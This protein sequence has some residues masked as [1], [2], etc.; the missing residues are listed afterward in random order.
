M[1]SIKNMDLDPDQVLKTA[2]NSNLCCTNSSF[3]FLYIE[4]AASFL[5]L[6]FSRLCKTIDNKSVTNSIQRLSVN[7]SPVGK[8]KKCLMNNAGTYIL[9]VYDKC[10]YVVELPS[11]WG[12]YEQYNGGSANTMC[13]S[14]RLSH[15]SDIEDAIWH[16][17][18]DQNR[19]VCLTKDNFIRIYNCENFKSSIKEYH[20]QSIFYEPNYTESKTNRDSKSNDQKV[21]ID[22]G[23]KFTFNGK[24][25]F[26]I[27]VLKSGGQ[28][29]CLIDYE[30]TSSFEFLGEL[31]LSPSSNVLEDVQVISIMCLPVHPN[32]IVVQLK[33]FTVYHCLFMPKIKH[34]LFNEDGQQ[35]YNDENTDYN[36]DAVLYI[37]ERVNINLSN[38]I[39]DTKFIKDPSNSSRYFIM[40]LGG[41]HSVYLPWLERLQVCYLNDT[42]LNSVDFDELKSCEFTHLISTRPFSEKKSDSFLVGV[43][44]LYGFGNTSNVLIGINNRAGFICANVQ[45]T[46]MYE[47]AKNQM[48]TV[49]GGKEENITDDEFNKYIS[50]ILKRQYN[51][52]ILNA[53]NVENLSENEL[54]LF[55][56]Q[57]INLIRFEYIEKQKLVMIEFQKRSK[58]LKQQ[59]QLQMNIVKEINE[60]T[61]ALTRK[62]SELVYNFEK[63]QQKELNL[64]K[65]I[66]NSFNKLLHKRPI[67]MNEKEK[68]VYK[69]IKHLKQETKDFEFQIKENKLLMNRTESISLQPETV[70]DPSEVDQLRNLIKNQ[71]DKMKLLMQKIEK[72][73][74]AVK[75]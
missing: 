44:V 75:I 65:N 62:K 28:I 12:K 50:G 3:L 51:L 54:N 60:K 21:N 26:P 61:E 67:L 13:K 74:V 36:N 39:Q 27:Y 34:F 15:S 29:E 5:A 43:G 4:Q 40:H 38:T 37:Y 66:E 19:V 23:M 63:Y 57:I 8:F 24:P 2:G 47:K 41:V 16:I 32:C 56:K 49:T 14:T 10:L 59:E 48:I 7:A 9:V 69:E 45:M 18:T 46:S 22:M 72:L 25:A 64:K 33:D 58:L 53:E 42:N 31:Q 73:K 17:R 11:K 70:I 6:S 20:L 55:M 1:Q 35:D 71:N 52:P 30:S 68:S